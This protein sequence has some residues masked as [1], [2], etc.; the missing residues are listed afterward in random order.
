[1]SR[2]EPKRKA[3]LQVRITNLIQEY[4]LG[5]GVIR[6]NLLD[7]VT[8]LPNYYG[9][10][11]KERVLD[12]IDPSKPVTVP[13]L[14]WRPLKQRRVKSVDLSKIKWAEPSTEVDTSHYTKAKGEISPL[15]FCRL[16]PF[17]FGNF[18]KYV[19]RAPYKGH[20]LED[21]KKACN[22]VS[23]AIQDILIDDKFERDLK[24]YAH[25]AKCFN[26]EFLNYIF[27]VDLLNR[28]ATEGVSPYYFRLV[29][30]K[31]QLLNKIDRLKAIG[32]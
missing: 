14:Q 10:E 17:N 7:A 13:N 15:D 22:Y 3:Q 20:E 28:Y 5:Y 2:S 31:K 1:M 4:G 6:A 16:F 8:N 25:L 23:L 26:N 30:V 18:C 29:G 21:L 19:L 9:W 27:N 11:S 24:Q 12:V 32:S